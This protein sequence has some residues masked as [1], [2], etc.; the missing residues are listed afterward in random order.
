MLVG[1][2]VRYKSAES[3]FLYH[4]YSGSELR[5][6]ISFGSKCLSPLSRAAGPE[7]GFCCI[8]YVD[9]FRVM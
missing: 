4:V 2:E 8:F 1:I 6:S 3:V 9:N 7:L 5:S